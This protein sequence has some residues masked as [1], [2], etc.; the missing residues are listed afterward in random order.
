MNPKQPPFP[1]LTHRSHKSE[2]FS[3]EKLN[4]SL[5]EEH[6]FGDRPADNF[7]RALPSQDSRVSKATAKDG[8][9]PTLLLCRT[10]ERRKFFSR[11]SL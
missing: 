9:I 1:Y 2:A 7:E 4:T 8:T 10:K 11:L 5:G 6:V 3:Y